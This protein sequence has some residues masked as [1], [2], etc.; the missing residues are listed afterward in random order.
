[1]FRRRLA[2]LGP[3][4]VILI[5]AV[6]F[7]RYEQ[8]IP[9]VQ[10]VSTAL[11]P[12]RV[13]SPDLRWPKGGQSALGAVGYGL[14]ASRNTDSPQPIAS[15]SKVITAL[16]V[17][18]KKPLSPGNGGPLIKLDSTDVGY[19]K[20][21]S[22]HGG[23]VA[24]VANGEQITEYQAL[25]ALL[26]PSANNMG[27]SLARWAFGSIPNYLSYARG[28]VSQMGLTNTTVGNTNG[29]DDK[30]TSNADDV[31]KIGLRAMQNPVLADIVALPATDI[32]VA[33][34]IGNVNWLLGSDGVVGIKTGNT[35]KAG[36]CYLFA[37]NQLVS[38]HKIILVGAVLGQPDLEEAINAAPP[39]INSAQKDFEQVTVAHVGQSLGYYKTPWGS[40][41]TFA[42]SKDLSLLAWKGA[43]LNTVNLASDI[44]SAKAGT[45]VG[46]VIV[47]GRPA[48]APLVLSNDLTG[49]S[50]WWRIIRH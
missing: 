32:P 24:K 39:L 13:S 20:Y 14:L 15:I 18:Q 44:R 26:L 9:A 35:T 11:K 45:H 50:F 27:D 29:F 36:G 47:A 6:G 3:T 5:L 34:N 37:S 17:L 46:Q 1:M 48:S 23:S 22:K 19:Y 12:T 42:P 31:V 10:A 21:Y 30:T 2:K 7:Y 49:P 4:L 33:G 25:E 43:Q 41:A 40:T 16:A 38:G 28:M 8:P